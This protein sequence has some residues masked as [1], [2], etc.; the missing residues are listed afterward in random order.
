PAAL[1]GAGRAAAAHGALVRAGGA[2]QSRVFADLLHPR[3]F[4]AIR[5]AGG[6]TPRSGL[7]LRAG[8]PRGIPAVDVRIPP[9]ARSAARRVARAGARVVGR[10]VPGTLVRGNSRLLLALAFQAHPI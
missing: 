10:A 2:G 8:L 5:D 3:A 7:L 1:T 6:I 4:R 9:G